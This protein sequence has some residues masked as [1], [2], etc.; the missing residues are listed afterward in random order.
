MIQSGLQVSDKLG[1]WLNTVLRSLQFY[2]PLKCGQ[3]Q[4]CVYINIYPIIVE[5]STHTHMQMIAHNAAYLPM[6][7]SHCNVIHI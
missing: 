3:V 6:M 7:R 4:I 5:I 1:V 2:W